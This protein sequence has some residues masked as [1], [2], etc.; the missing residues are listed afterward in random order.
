MTATQP[1]L[2]AVLGAATSLLGARLNQMVTVEEWVGL[3]RAVAACSGRTTAELLT[4]R[5][6]EEVADDPPLPWD[7]AVDGPLRTAEAD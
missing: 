2:E 1:Q 6:L 5:D 7:E 3:A 4:E